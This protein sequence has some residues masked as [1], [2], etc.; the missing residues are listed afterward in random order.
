MLSQ[1]L[2]DH[3]TVLAY[4][5]DGDGSFRVVPLITG[6]ELTIGR[7]KS[8]DVRLK[9]K[10]VSKLQACIEDRDGNWY[11]EDRSTYGTK[12][13]NRWASRS[14]LRDGDQLR[15][16]PVRLQFRNTRDQS[17][18]EGGTDA[19]PGDSLTP[20]EQRLVIP[21]C[22]PRLE[23]RRDPS[24]AALAEELHASKETV[25]GVLTG[26][27]RRFD[28]TDRKRGDKKTELI[29]LLV[30]RGYVTRAD[31]GRRPPR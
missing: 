20:P 28:L 26:L 21:L 3:H 4:D 7:G 24:I 8:C 17:L 16:G 11:L 31:I 6:E 10:K 1:G 2:I 12:I 30:D 22:T 18:T 27:Y 29:K 13:N 23:G 19:A 5:G 15:M 9:S 14:P 25:K